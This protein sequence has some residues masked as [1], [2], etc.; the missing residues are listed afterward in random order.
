MPNMSRRK[1]TRP[2]LIWSKHDNV[3]TTRTFSKA[4][5]LAALRLG[6][7]YCPPPLPRRS[8]ACVG[9]STLMRRHERRSRRFDDQAHIENSRAHNTQWRDWLVQQIG[10]LGHCRAHTQ[11]ISFSCNL[12]MRKK[13]RMPMRLMRQWGHS[14]RADRLWLAAYAAFECRHGSRQSRCPGRI[15]KVQKWGRQVSQPNIALIGLGLIGSSLGHALKKN[16]LA[17]HISGY[18]RSAAT[19]DKALELGFVDSV[20]DTAAEAVI[21]A[22]IVF[23]QHAAQRHKELAEEIVPGLKDNAILTDVGSVKARAERVTPLLEAAC[24][25]SPAI[26]LPAPN[27]PGRKPVLPNCS[28]ALVHFD[29]G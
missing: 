28:K 12:P 22:D 21:D 15:G 8:I 7:G 4:Y 5:G 6:W 29:T 9:R 1:I 11:P 26:R 13:R 25:S 27:N 17:A 19:R 18:A 14:A 10:G 2:L 23:L 24:I 20:H 3:V 16:K